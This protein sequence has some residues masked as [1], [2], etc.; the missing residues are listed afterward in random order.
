MQFGK[1]AFDK[2]DDN[3]CY[4]LLKT[5]MGLKPKAYKSG[6]CSFTGTIFKKNGLEIHDE[7]KIARRREHFY[8]LLNMK[9]TIV[10]SIDEYL[11]TQTDF[12]QL[13]FDDPFTNDEVMKSCVHLENVAMVMHLVQMV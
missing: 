8:D 7:V 10:D 1:T 2:S 4:K 12:I 3:T 9:D 11:P 6:K 13:M 5:S